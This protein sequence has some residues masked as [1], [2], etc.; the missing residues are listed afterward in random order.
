MFADEACQFGLR[1]AHIVFRR[2]RIDGGCVEQLARA[3]DH[4]NLD[5][6]A[7]A[8][9]KSH[10]RARTGRC[11]QQQILQVAGEDVDR[12][13]FRPLAQVAHQVK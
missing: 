5:A 9:I 12:F 3:I 2:E 1:A 11:R 6:G 4:G 8:G 7:D 13:F 10:G